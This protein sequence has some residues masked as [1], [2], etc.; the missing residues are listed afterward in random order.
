LACVE[1]LWSVSKNDLATA[2]LTTINDPC[3]STL[4]SFA[5]LAG[6][7]GIICFLLSGYCLESGDGIPA[8]KI[9]LI[10][11]V[12]IKKVFDVQ[13]PS[14]ISFSTPCV[15]ALVAFALLN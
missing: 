11:Q 9:R 10:E 7:F 15:F 5:I 8:N 2:R 12:S 13:K 6:S 1:T 3:L 4:T 14:L